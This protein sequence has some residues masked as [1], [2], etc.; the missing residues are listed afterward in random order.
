MGVSFLLNLNVLD[1][2]AVSKPTKPIVNA[3]LVIA[4]EVVSPIVSKIVLIKINFLL[5]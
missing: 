3:I 5:K 4:I 1:K 2:S